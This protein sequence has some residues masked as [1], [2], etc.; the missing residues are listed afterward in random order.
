M[1]FCERKLVFCAENIA[2]RVR[3]YIVTN[4]FARVSG[5]NFVALGVIT[6]EAEPVQSITKKTEPMLQV[7][8]PHSINEV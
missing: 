2:E 7:T 5:L 4:P 3:C 8:E 1:I 6:K